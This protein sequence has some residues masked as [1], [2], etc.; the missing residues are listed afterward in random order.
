MKVM[1]A[2]LKSVTERE[3]L[4]GVESPPVAPVRVWKV[5]NKSG[6]QV[7]HTRHFVGSVNFIGWVSGLK[8]GCCVI[9]EQR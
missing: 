8:G 9:G 3:L 4:S 1:M 6:Q 2:P 7:K 5:C